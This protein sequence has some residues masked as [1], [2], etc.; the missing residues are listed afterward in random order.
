MSSRKANN[1]WKGAKMAE[2]R[3]RDFPSTRADARRAHS[4]HYIFTS[5]ASSLFLFEGLLRTVNAEDS[6]Y[7]SSRVRSTWPFRHHTA[8]SHTVH[9]FAAR[10]QVFGVPYSEHGSFYELTCFALSF[11]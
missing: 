10:A 1:A 4:D 6:A 2:D 9:V 8:N 5:P 3:N 7:K 11:D